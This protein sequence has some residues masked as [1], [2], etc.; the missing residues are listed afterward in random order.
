MHPLSPALIIAA[1]SGVAGPDPSDS[2]SGAADAA[3]AAA[4]VGHV[5]YWAHYDEETAVSTW[6]F[7]LDADCETLARLAAKDG[8]LSM[9]K[10]EPGVIYLQWSR[11]QHAFRRAGIVIAR[12]RAFEHRSVRDCYDCLVLE[13]SAVLTRAQDPD[14]RHRGQERLETAV[15]WVRRKRV[16]CTPSEGDRFICWVD[17]DGRRVA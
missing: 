10:P 16:W 17:L 4:F 5:G 6:P 12:A 3:A 2:V 1:A 7:P 15:Q 8:I 11:R 13:G 14:G 9:R